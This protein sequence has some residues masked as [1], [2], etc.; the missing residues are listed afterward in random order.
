M[1]P[2]RKDPITVPK[3][4]LRRA[5]NF[6]HRFIST[7]LVTIRSPWREEGKKPS[8]MIREFFCS[9]P[10]QGGG[11]NGYTLLPCIVLLLLFGIPSHANERNSTGYVRS[12]PLLPTGIRVELLPKEQTT[13]SSETAARILT[14]AP[15]EGQK[16]K[17]NDTLVAF[18]CAMERAQLRRASAV[19][20]AAEAKSQVNERL[21][22]LQASSKLEQRVARAE[23]AQAKA[24][25][26]IIQV[27]IDRCTIQAPFSGRV[28][29]RFAH[30][31]QYVKAGDPLMDILNEESLEVVFLLPSRQRQ[32]LVLNGPF[33]VHID[34]TQRSY[35]A[36][37]TAFGAMIDSVSQSVKVFAMIE[38]HHPELLPG[39]SG[40]ATF[41]SL[42]NEPLE[43]GERAFPFS[44]P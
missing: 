43:V 36:R 41:P 39:M 26:A 23:F 7:L 5:N 24:D 28:N 22:H 4:T 2:I 16:F 35:S 42:K 10:F 18:D 17:K 15:R 33:Q 12:D 32:H 25:M 44:V 20:D 37:I 14:I 38:G 30:A 3:R 31:H 27:K 1:C 19:L 6:F 11:V 9:L 29:T 8:K 13:L 40:M 34:E 21:S